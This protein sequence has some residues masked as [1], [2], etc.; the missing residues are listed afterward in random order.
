[1]RVALLYGSLRPESLS[2]KL[3]LNAVELLQELGADAKP[4]DPSNLPVYGSVDGH[5]VARELVELCGWSDAQVWCTPETHGSF[6]GVLKNQLDW[7]P[8]ELGGK[9]I[10]RHKPVALLQVSGGSQSLNALN[11]MRLVARHLHMVAIP[12]QLSLAQAHLEFGEDGRLRAGKQRE[13]LQETLAEL[14]DFAR[15][16]RPPEV[17][18]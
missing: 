18:S 13:R 5:A 3:T 11:A 10:T 6:T 4:F 7:L 8:F 14:C 17:P 9:S 12:H 16:L 1:M 2:R 15:R